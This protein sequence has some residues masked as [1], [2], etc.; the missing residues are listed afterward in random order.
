M[1]VRN[2]GVL[3]HRYFSQLLEGFQSQGYAVGA[4]G[5]SG[6]WMNLGWRA[7]SKTGQGV[8]E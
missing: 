8:Q 5:P 2:D 3:V 7:D 6:L 4:S 1:E